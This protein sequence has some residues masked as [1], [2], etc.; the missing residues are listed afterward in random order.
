[1]IN[2]SVAQSKSA[3]FSLFC[4]IPSD[5]VDAKSLAANVAEVITVPS[6]ATKILF[7]CSGIFY[8]KHNAA[9]TVPGDTA[10]GTASVLNPS[11]WV[12]T[13]ADTIGIIAPAACVCTLEYF[14]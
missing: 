12:V 2:L 5:Y 13:A 11:G 14:K 1:M 10:D 7:S 3:K 8:A 6:D 4:V 9:A